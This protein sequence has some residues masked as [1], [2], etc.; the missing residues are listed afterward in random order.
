[1]AYTLKICNFNDNTM[2]FAS[3]VNNLHRS[4]L[5]FWS[6]APGSISKNYIENKVYDNLKNPTMLGT[7]VCQKATGKIQMSTTTSNFYMEALVQ[8]KL[9]T[10]KSGAFCYAYAFNPIE[11]VYD[12]GDPPCVMT[13]RAFTIHMNNRFSFIL[14]SHYIGVFLLQTEAYCVVADGD[15]AGTSCAD[16]IDSMTDANYHNFT[17]TYSWK[18]RLY[19]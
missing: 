11:F 10:S 14:S 18:V 5:K 2:G 17:G 7:K 3:I 13:V 12:Y 15:W 4:H 6:T 8:G 9:Q 16:Y 19:W 1:M